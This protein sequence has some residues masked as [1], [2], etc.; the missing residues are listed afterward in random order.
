MCDN[1][2]IQCCTFR[3][4]RLADIGKVE[5]EVEVNL[6]PTVIPPVFPVVTRPSGTRDQFFFSL[7]FPLD[8][9]GFS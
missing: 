1:S 2:F 9:Y 8:S 6:R 4:E 5:V 7:K 3:L